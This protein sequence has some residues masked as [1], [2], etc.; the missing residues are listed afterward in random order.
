MF[1]DKLAGGGSETLKKAKKVFEDM[2]SC[3]HDTYVPVSID[4]LL[5]SEAEL[6]LE[7]FQDCYQLQVKE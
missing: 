5:L 3:V 1:A 7:D 6:T 4:E 2:M